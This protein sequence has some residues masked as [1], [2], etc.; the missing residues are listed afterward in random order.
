MNKDYLFQVSVRDWIENSLGTEIMIPVYGGM[1]NNDYD[2]FVQSFLLPE[3]MLEQEM[4]ND[5]Y[6]AHN[7]IPGITVY[8]LWED[9]EKVYHQW[10]NGTGFEPIV[11]KRDFNGLMPDSIEIVEEFRLLFNLYYNSQKEEYIDLSN[12]E[13]VTVVKMNDNGYTTIHKRYLKTFLAVKEKVLLLH[14]DSRCTRLDDTIKLR[15]DR[16]VYRN[17]EKTLLYTLNIGNTSTLAKNDNYSYIYA[18]KVI[19]G[20]NLCDSNI[21]PYNKEKNYIEYIIGLDENGMELKYTCN[22][23]KLSNY[24]GA[25]PS[26]PHYLTPVYFD[27]AVLEKYYSKPEIYKIE[28]GIIRCGSLWALYID[29]TKDGYVSAYLGDLGRDLPSEQEQHYWRGFNKAIGGHLSQTKFKRD[30]MA[31]AADSDSADFVF[32]RTFVRVNA[33]FEKQFGWTLFLAL[34]EQDAYIFE[35]LRIPINNSVAEMDMLVLSLVKILIDSLNE[36][37]IVEQLNEEYVKL[38][39]SISKIEAWF[40]EKRIEDYDNHIKFLRNLQELRSTGTGH[41]KGKG[42][43]KISKTLDVQKENY[44]DTFA[45]L[46]NKS[47]K[48]LTFIEEIIPNLSN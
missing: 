8:G 37:K 13:S 35:T 5:T 48:F 40:T 30:F 4:D 23:E 17:N 19:Y 34:S 43:Q 45:N 46:L 18:K 26:A 44:A 1:V 24:F 36:K 28:D 29:N 22:P 21:W 33:K 11:I 16:L 47:T 41:L 10:G 42:Y 32:K 15:N 20:C 38:V 12:G 6:N 9:D 31:I 3:D 39:G 25:N 2:I 14:I 27:A 7:L